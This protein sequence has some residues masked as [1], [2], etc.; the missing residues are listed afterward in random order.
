MSTSAITST[1]TEREPKPMPLMHSFIT[2][3]SKTL[4]DGTLIAGK[5][6]RICISQRDNKSEKTTLLAYDKVTWDK[7]TPSISSLYA[8]TVAKPSNEV[9][10][11]QAPIHFSIDLTND[12]IICDGNVVSKNEFAISAKAAYKTLND[13]L[14]KNP[15]HA[16]YEISIAPKPSPNAKQE[17][18]PYNLRNS[19][20]IN[21]TDD[22]QLWLKDETI[23]TYFE[24][25]QKAEAEKGNFFYYHMVMKHQVDVANIELTHPSL[26]N[27]CPESGQFFLPIHHE[28]H[29]VM[30]AI[31]FDQKTI[32]F[33]D[34]RSHGVN[35]YKSV[36]NLQ[37]GLNRK[38]FNGAATLVDNKNQKNHQKDA[39]NC[40]RYVLDAAQ[41]MIAG[42][43]N[44][45]DAFERYC[46]NKIDATEI[47]I[48]AN[49]KASAIEAV[50][51]NEISQELI[52]EL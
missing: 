19:K 12:S 49:Q 15:P 3:T 14:A 43:N 34:P 11:H 27:N 30:I 26:G 42:S 40:G 52:D 17:Q 7:L 38:Y 5:T 20:K 51:E 22:K 50:Y 21:G 32:F 41:K 16:K 33:Y 29:Y 8:E 31:D 6:L 2:L 10:A 9:K 44:S 28:N 13:N 45:L 46:N 35:H 23:I 18:V 39:F 37:E 25:L 24:C 47:A 1:E 36:Q 48:R 4:E